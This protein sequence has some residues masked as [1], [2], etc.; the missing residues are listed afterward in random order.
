MRMKF[1]S[2]IRRTASSPGPSRQSWAAVL[3]SPATSLIG[4]TAAG[5]S[6]GAVT[7][8]GQSSGPMDGYVETL[9]RGDPAAQNAGTN[10]ADAREI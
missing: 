7:S 10:P 4:G 2:A 5:V 8:A 6:Q 3:A 1:T 9:L